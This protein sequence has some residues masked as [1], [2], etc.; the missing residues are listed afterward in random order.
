MT[1]LD[2]IENRKLT[3]KYD[4]NFLFNIAEDFGEFS[5]TNAF[6]AESEDMIKDALCCY[7]DDFK[8][9][10]SFKDFINSVNWL[11]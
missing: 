1:I 5:I 10:E 11:N 9:D 4:P 7:I 6:E 3:K 8:Y 2:I